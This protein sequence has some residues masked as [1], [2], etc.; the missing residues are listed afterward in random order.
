MGQLLVVTATINGSRSV[1]LIVDTGAS[2]TILSEAVARDLGYHRDGGAMV[3]FKT[4]GG[5]IQARMVTADSI[6][7]ADAR[8]VDI[9]VAIHD[10]SDAP[11]GIDGLLGMTFLDH[12]TIA[13]DLD[14]SQLQLQRRL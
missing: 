12:F 7:L 8:L 1:R 9:P 5:L 11:S 10:V 2:H 4:A 13:L 3:T 6:Q 14:K